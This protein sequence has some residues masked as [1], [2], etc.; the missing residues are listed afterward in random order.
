[1]DRFESLKGIT[2]NVEIEFWKEH[3]EGMDT[4]M[5]SHS[6]DMTRY[7]KLWKS[8]CDAFADNSKLRFVNSSIYKHGPYAITLETYLK[9]RRL[10][11][12]ENINQDR[13]GE[14]YK[15]MTYFHQIIV[16]RFYQF[17]DE[18]LS[19]HVK[20]L[21]HK[22]ID[23]TS[24]LAI[25][26][27]EWSKYICALNMVENQYS[28]ICDRCKKWGLPKI[29]T[30]GVSI[31]KT[32]FYD[33]IADALTT[34]I[35]QEISNDRKQLPINDIAIK[36]TI[37]SIMMMGTDPLLAIDDSRNKKL[38]ITKF[39]ERFLM[40]LM[41][42]YSEL[43]N[44]TFD[45]MS[46]AD[47][48]RLCAKSRNNEIE[49]IKKYLHAESQ[50]R[51]LYVL[52]KYMIK[53]HADDFLTLLDNM[54]ILDNLEDIGRIY[55]LIHNLDNGQSPIIEQ[56]LKKYEKYAMLDIT[57]Q[58]EN[59]E[60][61]PTAY[62]QFT[63][64][65]LRLYRKYKKYH[66]EA[67]SND[68]QPVKAPVIVRPIVVTNQEST[69]VQ[70]PQTA[71]FL[72]KIKEPKPILKPVRDKVKECTFR[73]FV[74]MVNKNR[75]CIE[76][77]PCKTSE[78]L[79]VYVNDLMKNANMTV[80]EW[81]ATLGDIGD[82]TYYIDDKDVFTTFYTKFLSNRLIVDSYK[83]DMEDFM[84]MKLRNACGRTLT[85]KMEVMFKDLKTSETM[86]EEFKK[87]RPPVTEDDKITFNMRVLTSGSWSI[88]CISAKLNVPEVLKPSMDI[89]GQYYKKHYLRRT[90][91]WLYNFSKCEITMARGFMDKPYIFQMNTFQLG[92]LNT[93][94][95]VQ[96]VDYAIIA[97]TTGMDYDH[98]Q[99]TLKT[100]LKTQ[101][102]VSNPP[103]KFEMQDGRIVDKPIANGTKF[104]L[105]R[106]FSKQKLKLNLDIKLKLVKQ[107]ETESTYQEIE[108]ERKF[109][110]DAAIVRI[111]KSRNK[112]GYL[113]LQTEVISQV[114][115]YFTPSIP[116]IKSRI[117]HLIEENY[118]ERN[119]ENAA[120]YW[121]VA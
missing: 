90:L 17:L 48:M 64:T 1:M 21:V 77:D 118:I 33:P 29:Q 101:V 18:Y 74:H 92:V 67:F 20:G 70:Q 55:Q 2:D 19:Q 79:S 98:L 111:M 89:F 35:L 109:N 30:L 83:E 31:W 75:I 80:E 81:E 43:S 36:T 106:K 37:T 44:T 10:P 72:K 49:R 116:L 42:Y 41:I 97:A 121:Y 107:K 112:M 65:L 87:W 58:F 93:L 47:Y 13:L 56:F 45:T 51:P 16:V 102:L 40:D 11:F 120:E 22:L 96:T 66:I 73:L 100:L 57:T 110:V 25:Y 62:K 8:L 71:K 4:I 27:T 84:F 69:T 94:I 32:Y 50:S 114:C 60:I 108:G 3:I 52:E 88:P 6:F 95:E 24:Y 28:R 34:E 46:L 113:E 7:R 63:D 15:E 14:I 119:P 54:L 86:N 12:L 99:T 105:N 61:T 104:Q 23:K 85:Y 91:M 5:K 78:L 59:S 115:K 103:Y 82:M 117:G 68:M 53:S 39:E 38:Y 26:E 76:L 9:E